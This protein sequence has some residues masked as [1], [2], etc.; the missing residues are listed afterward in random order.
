M[1]GLSHRG[2]RPRLKR[3]R[4]KASSL[5]RVKRARCYGLG[6]CLRDLIQI[7]L[8]R[9]GSALAVVI[10]ASETAPV[11]LLFFR[12]L[13]HLLLPLLLLFLLLHWQ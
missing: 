5:D 12:L 10:V 4:I 1:V 6:S 7:S 8:H 3:A 11:A 13:A 2:W 9:L